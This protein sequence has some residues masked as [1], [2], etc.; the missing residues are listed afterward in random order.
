MFRLL[1]FVLVLLV[2]LPVVV[3]AGAKPALRSM[4]V[5]DLFKFKRVGDPQIS[6]DGK[7][8]AYVV[9]SVDLE[10]NKTSSA[11]WLAPVAGKGSPRALTTSGKKDRHPRWSPDGRHILFESNRSGNFQLWVID[12]TGGEARQLTEIS[13]EANTGLWSADGKS[14]AF[15]SAVHPEFSHKPF[16]QSDA[17]NKK[18]LEEAEKNPV[19]A[20]VFTRL[21]FRH[22]DSYVEDRRQHLFVIP[23]TPE[24]IAE[25]RDV[26]P[27]DRD[28]NPTS[29]TFSMGD[30]FTFSPDSQY[31]LF[32]AV[33]AVDEAW[34]TNYDLCRVSVHGGKVE[35]LTESNEAADGTP[36]FSPDGKQLAYRAQKRAGY[37]ADRW[38][39]YIVATDA[40]GAW[41]GKPRSI[42]EQFDGSPENFAWAADGRTIYFSADHEA[43]QPIFQADLETGE[44]R[45]WLEGNTNTA[46]SVSRDGKSLAFVRVAMHH[47]H[48]VFLA[49]GLDSRVPGG[50]EVR[51]L[52]RANSRL[53]SQ[54]NLPLPESVT[55][56]G[57]GGTPM[58]MWI[59][60][61]PGF[62]EKKKWPVAYLVHGGPQGAWEDGWS[63]RWCPE[64]W[65]A[66][67][68]VVALPNPRGSTGFGQ[69]YVDE[70]SGDWGG[71][72]YEDLM[73]GLDHLEKQPWVDKERIGA[74]GASFGGY[75]MNWFAVNTGRFKC[76]ITHCSVWNFES[77]YATTDELW[78]DE[79]EHGGPP[80]GPNRKAYEKHSPHRFAAN[81]GKYKTPML[82]IHN[83]NDFRCPIGQGHELFTSLQ[84]QKVLSRFINFPD[85]G[86]WVL[87]PKN[88]EY[89]HKEVFGWLTKHVPPGGRDS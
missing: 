59:L 27:G 19:K 67:G 15:V 20:R 4:K 81:L 43:R 32:T 30:D 38:Q 55:V 66:Q 77:M 29:D 25:P 74:A 35:C 45:K 48:E 11:I 1:P 39:L 65:A 12:V 80:W 41:K 71:R 84:R 7:T 22:W 23:F 56:K 52:S 69:K 87:K 24:K 9:T 50:V 57:A 54:L 85:E 83:D 62:D 44:V 28:A 14:I 47:P 61:P 18:K 88:S 5:E 68:Y 42:T 40:S 2:G 34:S 3:S 70:I 72:C 16:K 6:P 64:V 75:M 53:L 58:Q 17:D 82:V 63:F 86:H 78:F 49:S 26:T 76:L 36:R 37:E 10:G 60:K 89:W 21:F 73:K 8:V 46:L 33:P 51:N 13:T 79:W 31:L